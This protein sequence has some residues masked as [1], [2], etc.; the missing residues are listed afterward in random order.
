MNDK[1]AGFVI[2][3]TM[4]KLAKWLRIMGIDAH[5]QHS[6]KKIE[7]ENL[8]KEGRILLTRSRALKDDLRPSILIHSEKVQ[9][10]L[11]ELKESGLLPATGKNWF[12][13]CIRCNIPLQSVQIED[14]RGRIPE[15][16][17][18]QN[19]EWVH[20]CPSCNRY[21]WPG[22]HRERMLKQIK[23]WGILKKENTT[24]PL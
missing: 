23:E 13:R 6:Y 20:K 18:N 14:A 12:Q 21:F 4:G 3:T 2:D 8:I 24:P 11:M 19:I 22:S 5:Y 10:Q 17:A 15:H 9:N 16:T 7:I 1:S